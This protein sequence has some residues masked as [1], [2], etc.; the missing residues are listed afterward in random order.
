MLIKEIVRL[1]TIRLVFNSSEVKRADMMALLELKKALIH[2]ALPLLFV[3]V[4][5]RRRCSPLVRV[6]SLKKE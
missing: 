5:I 6:G 4:F 3:R 2:F 1:S